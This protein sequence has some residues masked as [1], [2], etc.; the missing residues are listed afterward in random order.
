MK[1]YLFPIVVFTTIATLI[2]G[3]NFGYDHPDSF[4]IE[5]FEFIE[6]P[7]G[8]TCG[9]TSALMLLKKYGKDVTLDDVKSQTKTEWI[10]YG[11]EPIG[12][13]SPEYIPVALGHFGLSSKNLRGDLNRLKYFVSKKRPVIV[14]LRSGKQT[15]HYVVVIGYTEDT[16]ITADPGPGKRKEI[17][18]EY[19]LGA[20]SFTHDMYGRNTQDD[21]S[22][23]GGTGRWLSNFG[24]FDHCEICSGTGKSVDY[25]V[26]LLRLAEVYPRTMIVPRIHIDEA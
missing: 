9:P 5:W 13:T 16:I 15:W 24:P 4:E 7:D 11:D 22:I 20:W 18:N 14:L 3:F 25:L 6:Q 1:K 2:W 19:F 17:K 10:Q 23:C 21:C 26:E 8:I 12:M